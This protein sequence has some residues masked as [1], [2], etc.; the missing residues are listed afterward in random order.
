VGEAFFSNGAIG[1]TI[2]T[3]SYHIENGK[4]KVVNFKRAVF[5]KKSPE[6][7]SGE[8]SYQ[9]KTLTDKT[10]Q[11]YET[12]ELLEL[13]TKRNLKI[14]LEEDNELLTLRT[15][16]HEFGH[17]WGL[18]DQ[19]ELGNHSTNCDPSFA[20][21]NHEGHVILEDD[22]V[23]NKGQWINKIYLTDDDITGI[24]KMGQRRNVDN[25]WPTF[26]VFEKIETL[27][28]GSPKEI[29]FASLKEVMISENSVT[30]TMALLTHSPSAEIIVE[31]FSDSWSRLGTFKLNKIIETNKFN[32]KLGTLRPIEAKKVKLII[33]TP[34]DIMT[35]EK[36]IPEE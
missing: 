22:S 26:S 4:K 28:E 5:L 18:C 11:N 8:N 30:F 13:L 19:Y 24:R 17:V 1:K 10:G 12:S 29:E 3:F 15:M 21:I 14:A 23:M 9:W 20:T 31:Q 33:K 25:T 34:N 2:P 7:S 36:E 16:I 27:P 32:L 35:L 6:N